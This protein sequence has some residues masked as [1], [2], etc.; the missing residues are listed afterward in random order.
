R[1]IFRYGSGRI[2][3][4]RPDDRDAAQHR[5]A[6][7]R[8]LDAIGFVLLAERDVLRQPAIGLDAPAPDPAKPD[9]AA[10]KPCR[11]QMYRRQ[12]LAGAHAANRLR[13]DE[14]RPAEIMA[15]RPDLPVER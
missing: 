11:A 15:D 14:I 6:A 2:G 10:G 7:V 3:P 8:D 9:I 4:F 5:A 1:E 12:R 13:G